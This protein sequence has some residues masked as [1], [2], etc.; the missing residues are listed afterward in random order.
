[1]LTCAALAEFLQWQLV[2][3][4][5]LPARLDVAAIGAVLHN[6]MLRWAASLSVVCLA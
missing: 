6:G 2:Y 1:M 3:F 4:F 5:L